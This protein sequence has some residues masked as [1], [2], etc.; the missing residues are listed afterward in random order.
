[1]G[2]VYGR[3]VGKRFG[4]EHMKKLLQRLRPM[5]PDRFALLVLADVAKNEPFIIVPRWW[6]AIWLFDR[7][8]PRLSLLAFGRI[9]ARAH[10]DLASHGVEAEA[11]PH[12]GPGVHA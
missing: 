8:A 11:P 9:Y 1:M 5:D 3:H 10:A 2:G 6:K 12:P 4:D 7:L